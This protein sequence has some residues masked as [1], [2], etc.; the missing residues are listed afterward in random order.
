MNY[1]QDRDRTGYATSQTTSAP[2][3][4]WND[5][6]TAGT[7]RTQYEPLHIVYFMKFV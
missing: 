2:A 6:E 7:V 1:G 4:T 3:L 5:G